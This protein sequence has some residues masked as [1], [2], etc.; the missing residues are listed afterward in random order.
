MRPREHRAFVFA[1]GAEASLRWLR[2]GTAGLRSA[3]ADQRAS[4]AE[5]IGGRALR[6]RCRPWDGRG[7][8]LPGRARVS[9]RGIEGS[10]CGVW[11]GAGVASARALVDQCG[12]E[13][14][15]G[16]D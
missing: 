11:V 4:H 3:H 2:G 12:A 15:D 16:S 13:V 8:G 10:E 5:S 7:E 6:S 9:G 14:G 1:D